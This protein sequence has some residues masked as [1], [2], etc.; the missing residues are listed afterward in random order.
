[1]KKTQ[2]QKPVQTQTQQMNA[3]R[4]EVKAI[5]QKL[6]KLHNK[7]EKLVKDIVRLQKIAASSRAKKRVSYIDWLENERR[8]K[9]LL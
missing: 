9:D 3:V 1:M 7:M 5:D 2:N 4:K 6:V 8:I